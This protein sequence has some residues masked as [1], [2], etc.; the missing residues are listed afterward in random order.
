MEHPDPSQCQHAQAVVMIKQTYL[1]C[2]GVAFFLVAHWYL[3][4]VGWPCCLVQGYL[5]KL[6]TSFVYGKKKR[7][8][9]VTDPLLSYTD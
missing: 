6:S 4:L 1:T 3:I 7:W 2:D 9:W 5:D 8:L